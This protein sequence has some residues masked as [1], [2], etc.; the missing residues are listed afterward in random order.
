MIKKNNLNRNAGGLKSVAADDN[1]AERRMIELY[2]EMQ[3]VFGQYVFWIREMLVF[4]ISGVKGRT[5]VIEKLKKQSDLIGAAFGVYY[6]ETVGQKIRRL[7]YDQSL[8]IIEL[9]RSYTYENTR[10]YDGTLVALQDNNRQLT[11]YYLSLGEGY[12]FEVL[13]EFLT[14]N[15]DDT[16][17]QI[18]RRF[19]G[20]FDGELS[21]FDSAYGNIISMADYLSDNIAK[22]IS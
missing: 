8:L 19:D 12:E 1:D 22:T 7:Y 4:I 20:E 6:D 10:L 21:S 15:V 5:E 17:L 18:R 11:E 16:A 13:S 2:C 3:G 14:K 9:A